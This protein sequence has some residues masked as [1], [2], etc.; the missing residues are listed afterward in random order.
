VRYALNGSCTSLTAVVGVDDEKG[1]EGSVVFQVWTDGV[2]QFDSGVVTGAMPGAAVSVSVVGVTEI[3]LIVT[4]GG[5]GTWSDHADWADVRVSCGADRSVPT[6]PTATTTTTT[7]APAAGAS[8]V[9]GTTTATGAVP[10]RTTAKQNAPASSANSAARVR[11][12][13][14]MARAADR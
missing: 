12:V 10:G 14:A 11:K 3:A 4:D 1:A 8:K 2:K 7:T 13:P 6:V 5:D 9:A